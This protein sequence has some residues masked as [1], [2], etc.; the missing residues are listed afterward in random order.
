MG[1]LLTHLS[2]QFRCPTINRNI[3]I[4]LATLQIALRTRRTSN[5]FFKTPKVFTVLIEYFEIPIYR[6]PSVQPGDNTNP[7]TLR[8]RRGRT[9]ASSGIS[10]NLSPKYFINPPIPKP[11]NYPQNQW[12][13]ADKNHFRQGLNRHHPTYGKS[14]HPRVFF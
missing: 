1:F 7:T 13:R 5:H 12:H 2:V 11:D 8:P 10:F 6:K 9:T 4:L 3:S 14:L